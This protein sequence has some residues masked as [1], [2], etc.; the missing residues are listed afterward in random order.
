VIGEGD[1]PKELRLAGYINRFGAQA[2]LGRAI[3]AKEVKH[4]TAAE[5]VVN[6]YHSMQNAQNAAEWAGS[7][8]DAA[9]LIDYAIKLVKNGRK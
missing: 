3:S 4:I 7:N 5:N 8:P 9:D 6:I 1:I 2:V